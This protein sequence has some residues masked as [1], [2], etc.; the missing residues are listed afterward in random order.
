MAYNF[1]TNFEK[2]SYKQ[3]LIGYSPVP[4]AINIKK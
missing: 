3:I 1:K 4:L 2:A